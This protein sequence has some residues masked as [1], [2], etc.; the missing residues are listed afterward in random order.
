VLPSDLVIAVLPHLIPAATIPNEDVERAQTEPL[1]AGRDEVLYLICS[2]PRVRLGAMLPDGT[3]PAHVAHGELGGGIRWDPRSWWARV[4]LPAHAAPSKIGWAVIDTALD[5][6]E[7]LPPRDATFESDPDGP[8]AENRQELLTWVYD[9]HLELV[10]PPPVQRGSVQGGAID[11]RLEYV[12]LSACEALRRAAGAHHKMPLI[13]GRVLLYEPHRL[14]YVLPCEI[15]VLMYDAADPSPP[16]RLLAL[17]EAVAAYAV[18][19]TLLI[20]AAEHALIA[21]GGTLY[22]KRNAVKR[23]FPDTAAG[24]ELQRLGVRTVMLGFWGLPPRVRVSGAA[25]FEHDAPVM[26]FDLAR[27]RRSAARPGAKVP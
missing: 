18:D 16:A 22:N 8:D 5:W 27:R 20:D 13:L 21:L 24:D 1:A 15:R 4:A 3:H 9:R 19:R 7:H 10:A 26:S 11:F 6:A 25:S 2:H 23:V 12:G 17:D 14:V